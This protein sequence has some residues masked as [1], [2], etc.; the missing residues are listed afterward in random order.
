M[1]PQA[2]LEPAT[3]EFSIRCSTIGAIVANCLAYPL[4]LEPRIKILEIS[5]LPITLWIHK[6]GSHFKCYHYTTVVTNLLLG[7]EPRPSFL[8]KV[9]F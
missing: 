9:K 1:V 2:G 7:F 6:T 3:H 5:V 4:G 8:Q